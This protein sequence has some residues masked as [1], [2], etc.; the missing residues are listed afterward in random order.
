MQEVTQEQVTTCL[1]ALG[2]APGDGLLVHSAVQ[3]LGRPVGG[4][5]MYLEAIQEETGPD[6]TLV[7]PTFKFWLR[8]RRKF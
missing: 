5:K 4:L 3:F 7:V 1:K 2:I 8:P 6:G